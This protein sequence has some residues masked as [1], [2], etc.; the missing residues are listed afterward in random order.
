MFI[1]A[2]QFDTVS[3]NSINGTIVIKWTFE[4]TGGLDTTVDIN[5]QNDDDEGS[6]LHVT[7]VLSCG[8][9][10]CSKDVL[11]GNGTLDPVIAGEIYSCNVTAINN[12]GTDSRSINTIPITEGIVMVIE[13]MV[14]AL[15]YS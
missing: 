4:H 6:E 3:A 9:D 12:N 11:M 15:C 2:P 10:G 8:Y 13:S 7:G 1:V 14:R 5:C